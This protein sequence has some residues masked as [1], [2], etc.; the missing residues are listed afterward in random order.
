MQALDTEGNET[1]K[2]EVKKVQ[3]EQHI[4]NSKATHYSIPRK[5]DSI[6]LTEHNLC[7]STL[8]T[9]RNIVGES[10]NI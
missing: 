4:T 9:E 1:A 3:Y 8:Y 7:H 6:L 2:E 10:V 5:K